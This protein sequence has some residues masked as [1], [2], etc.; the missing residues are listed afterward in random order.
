MCT[1]WKS[2]IGLFIAILGSLAISLL[3]PAL[4]NA[5]DFEAASP[6][7]EPPVITQHQVLQVAA[8][9]AS[10]VTVPY[11]LPDANDNIDGNVPVSCSPTPNS[12][13]SL[14]QTLVECQAQDAAGN[15]ATISFTI[16]VTDQTPPV[17]VAQ[18]DVVVD[19][20]D[21]SGSPVSYPAPVATDNV[22]GTVGVVCDVESGANFPIGATVVTCNANDAAGNSARPIAFQ[23]IVN[24]LPTPTATEPPEATEAPTATSESNEVESPTPTETPKSTNDPAA[25]ETPTATKPPSKETETPDA[26][27]TP[28]ASKKTN[29]TKT[30]STSTPTPKEK[31][32]IPPA[33]ALPWPPPDSF[34]LV[35]DGGPIDGLGAIWRNQ[36]FPITQEF[37]HTDFSVRHHRWYA[38]GAAFG[39]DGYEHPGIDIGMP[40]GTWL[41][42]PV[43]GVVKVAGG[44]PNYTYYGNSQPGVGELMIETDDGDE[45]IFGHMGLITVEEGQR[46]EVGQF[47]G[48]SGG[49]NGDHLHLE[50]REK[51]W[52]GGYVIVDP[53]KSF[54]IESLQ[55]AAR[56]NDPDEPAADKP[57]NRKSK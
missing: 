41:Y 28:S 13:F 1:I 54:L 34:V 35:T 26:S 45:V 51:Q 40:A 17:I 25:T 27:K 39:L 31:K 37:G 10:G 38:Y 24:P 11:Q 42:S 52:W 47:I 8:V 43:D 50:T 19:A 30:P 20:V 49:D 22:D 33:L 55:K 14:G 9:D 3:A 56:K 15:Q 53:R 23:V 6:D 18:P 57:K 32:K 16:T 21:P 12:L 2:R 29:Q 48:L 4:A 46:V 5:Q 36:D 7:T 44:V